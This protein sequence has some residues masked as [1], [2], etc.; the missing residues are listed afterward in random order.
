LNRKT[1]SSNDLSQGLAVDLEIVPRRLKAV[2]AAN[3]LFYLVSAKRIREKNSR[4]K[5]KDASHSV[6]MSGNGT[7]L[8]SPHSTSSLSVRYPLGLMSS[9]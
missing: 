1:E 7:M 5:S 2:L 6:M 4:E 8:S 9:S 3:F